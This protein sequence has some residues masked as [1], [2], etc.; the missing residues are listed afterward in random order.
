MDRF[1]LKRT[2]PETDLAGT[3]RPV[4]P[5]QDRLTHLPSEK[6]NLDE[7]PHDPANRKRILQNIKNPRKQDDIRFRYLMK[8]PYM[9]LFSYVY[10]HRD[11]GDGRR[12]NPGWFKEGNC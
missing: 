2:A 6:I 3:S 10:P 4:R 5:R 1:L 11:I 9:P 7:L 8:G 12:F